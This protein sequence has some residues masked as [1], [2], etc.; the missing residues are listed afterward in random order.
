MT[1]PITNSPLEKTPLLVG[2]SPNE[3]KLSV[4]QSVKDDQELEFSQQVTT[5]DKKRNSKWRQCWKSLVLYLLTI[6]MVVAKSCDTVLYVRLTYEIQ[7]Y[8]YMLTNFVNVAYVIILFPIVVF[9]IWRGKIT[10]AMRETRQYKY[11]V[12]AFLDNATNTLSTIPAAFVSGSVNTMLSQAVIVLNIAFSFIFLHARYNS[13]HMSGV[14]LVVCGLVINIYPLFAQGVS[15]SND[16][17]SSNMNWLWV[18]LL[19][20]SN[21]PAAASNVYK[22]KC[23]KQEQLDVWLVNY[24]V[25]VW[26]VL[27]GILTSLFVF[28]PMP[29]TSY[30]DWFGIPAYIWGGIKC[31]VGVN[32]IID[33]AVPD[34]CEGFPAVFWIDL[35]FNFTYATLELYVFQYGS[36]TLAVICSFL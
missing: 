29:G 34:R 4:N 15:I 24:W 21:I 33:G 26:Q 16:D 1:V 10:K 30:T 3:L 20:S 36:S 13:F 2:D 27:F 19:F 17:T 18:L 14:I 31:S 28:V 6:I 22:E 35:F 23:L 12:M 25:S 7:N 5:V 32:T 9:Q 8:I 11:I